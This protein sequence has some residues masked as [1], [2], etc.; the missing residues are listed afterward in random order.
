[1]I[2]Q[3]TLRPESF[4]NPPL[5]VYATLPAVWLQQ[6][7]AALGLLRGRAADPLLAGRLLS[8]LAGALAVLLLGRAALRAH[9][10]LSFWPALLLAVA[11]GFVNLCHFATPESWLML[12]AAA[13]LA[14]AL[15]HLRGRAPAWAVGLVLGLTVS[16]KH[17]ALALLAPCLAAVWMAPVPAG[18]ERRRRLGPAAALAL[19]AGMLAIA[20]A[21]YGGAGAALAAHLRLRDPRLLPLESALAFARAAAGAAALGGALLVAL[22]A[23]ALRGPAWARAG[24]R[25][26]LAVLLLM[27]AAGFVVGTPHALLDPPAVLS[28]LAFNYETRLQYKGLTGAATSFGPYALL[29]SDALT[30][31]LL[32]AVLAGLVIALARAARREAASLVVALAALAPY[33]LVA[34]SGHQ[35]LRFLAPLLPAAAW[36]GALALAA[37]AHPRARRLLRVLVAGRA[38]LASVLV[39]RL[40]FVDSRLQAQRWLRN[41]VAPGETIDL[42]ANSPGYAPAAPPGVALRVVPTLSREMAPADRFREAAAGYAVDGASWLVLTASY[43]QRF[44]DHPDQRPERTAFF[45]H[46]LEGRGGYEVAARFRQRGW[47]RPPAEF[48]DPEIVVLRKRGSGSG[49]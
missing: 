16:T 25:P 10:A 34:S 3:R 4:I 47:L 26:E 20:V 45:N 43:Y 46:L 30:A 23:L 40:F 42:I 18:D 29:L 11:P 27:A 1:M 19:G 44:L 15:A 6:R 28:G 13:T 17:T 41:A 37:P 39:V 38:A 12:G 24:A 31:P 36:L 49:P 33:L 35:A 5:P 48:V 22:G 7:A 2:S 21:L 14:V 9:P 8:A 32:A